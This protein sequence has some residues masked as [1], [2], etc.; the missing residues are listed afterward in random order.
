MEK[1]DSNKIE[2]ILVPIDYSEYSL[3]A[4]R[5]AIKIA[6]KTK[7]K[8]KLFHAYYSPALDLIDLA[9]TSHT[10]MQLRT[11]V[12]QNLE[13]TEKISIENFIKELIPYCKDSK[14]DTKN[15]TY[16]IVP[17][18]AEEAI[19]NY[20]SDFSP[21]LVV[22]GTRGK[23]KRANAILGSVTAMV[24]ERIK[25]PILAIP[26]QYEFIGE[27]NVDH[28]LYVTNFDES[29]FVSIQ[30]LMKLTIPLNLKIFCVHI[31]DQ[32]ENWNSV[33]MDGLKEYFKKAYG[34]TRVECGFIESNNLLHNI[35]DY[36]L[37]NKINI[38]SLT[39]RRRSLFEKIFKTSL[40]KKLFY[41]TNIPLLVFHS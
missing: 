32:P 2:N 27:E 24:I 1:P 30:K 22:M 41:H 9:G 18:I 20:C 8:I 17:G 4:C 40:T 38:V 3:L 13:D 16:D 5:Y 29:D 26:E 39:S 6:V 34:E 31:S 28:I 23:D 21:D 36:V 10:Q 11:D 19:V 15:V 35:E 37:H 7:A 33:K 25:F 12:V 14:Y